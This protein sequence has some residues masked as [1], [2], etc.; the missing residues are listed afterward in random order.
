MDVLSVQDNCSQQCPRCAT[1][2]TV[3]CARLTASEWALCDRC[4]DRSIAAKI[5]AFRVVRKFKYA[6]GTPS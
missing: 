5:A 1:Y 2:F 6:G 3:A 4:W